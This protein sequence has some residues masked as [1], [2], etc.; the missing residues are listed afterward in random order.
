[1]W[2]ESIEVTGFSASPKDKVEF[3]R[4]AVNLLEEVT[5]Q[6]KLLVPVAVLAA[7][8]GTMANDDEGVD[9]R[10]KVKRFRARDES[11]APFQVVID[12]VIDDRKLRLLR[13][14]LNNEA[15]VYDRTNHTTEVTNEFVRDGL[16][17]GETITG[18][19]RTRFEKACLLLPIQ[20][21]ARRN[22]EHIVLDFM[23]NTAGDGSPLFQE[24]QAV[25]T[26]DE[27]I[28]HFP[29]RT[30]NVKVDF[31]ID[32]LRRQQADI[33]K[34][35]ENYFSRRRA[36][37]PLI[38]RL[39]E[40]EPQ[41]EEEEKRLLADEYFRACLRA[42]ETDGSIMQLRTQRARLQAK[43]RELARL[44]TLQPQTVESQRQVEEL[45]NRRL[46]LL[47]ELNVLTEAVG[48]KI[49]EYDRLEQANQGE[50]ASLQ[51]FTVEHA[52]A[53][54]EIANR[55]A[56]MERELDEFNFQLG[57]RQI[58]LSKQSNVDLKKFEI[59]RK[60]MQALDPQDAN[61]AKSYAALL[62]GFRNQAAEA[63]K[64]KWRA[65]SLINEIEEQRRSKAGVSPLLM[66]FKAN[67]LRQKE[68]EGA[69]ADL[70]RHSAKL[71][72]WKTKIAG[73]EQRL[74]HLAKKA[75][76]EDGELLMKHI[77]EY[78]MA[79]N[80][81]KELDILKQMIE[82]RERN[83]ERLRSE[84][85]P[86]FNKAGRKNEEITSRSAKDLA[87]NILHFRS[88]VV[89]MENDYGPVKEHKEHLQILQA[90][91]NNIDEILA[92]L[93]S[94]AGVE[95]LEDV[96]AG[97]A[98][99][100]S[101]VS[102]FH[103]SRAVEDDIEK[104]LEQAGLHESGED[105][106]AKITRLEQERRT[107]WERIQF[108]VD[109][110]PEIADQIPPTGEQLASKRSPVMNEETLQL[111]GEC[112]QLRAQVRAFFSQSENEYSTLTEKL[113]AI[114]RVLARTES[115]KLALELAKTKLNELLE[116]DFSRLSIES[117]PSL[118]GAFEELPYFIDVSCLG[119]GDI[120][121]CLALKFL[122]VFARKRQIILMC[123][124]HKLNVNRLIQS[125]ALEEEP[126]KFCQRTPTTRDGSLQK[127]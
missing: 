112:D 82:A 61:D 72:E 71:D 14:L 43:R 117:L 63:D 123:N 7:L 93:F 23:I 65:E 3:G 25:H 36:T 110:Y 18:C 92:Q 30:I 88:D 32:E 19:D 69:R 102:A 73:L 97:Y 5:D 42:A 53:L 96:D 105:I 119:H 113:Q 16:S 78:G 2:I 91:L 4:S 67:T 115:N 81:V 12:F 94:E 41:V 75:G 39:R 95:N 84:L 80:K 107:T 48:A 126:I 57:Q 118:K 99:Y 114:E 35:L 90:E 79:S 122:G 83:M 44:D 50:L 74:Q 8:F 45:W 86:Y 40:I 51:G 47:S 101:R 34:K 52:Q 85:E 104:I 127:A 111:M 37:L 55:F 17:L 15:I 64:A 66:V 27:L 58:S 87:E 26:I 59:C 29:Y 13:N 106:N 6:A 77:H 56:T 100:Y 68:L 38:A 120:E 21:G 60:T 76:V 103:H 11:E 124:S 49:S 125:M 10:L 22:G 28:N 9:E 31:L 116:K 20:A 109:N 121:L 24:A 54:Q 1:M 108:L 33:E 62:T 89:S 46:G 70:Q 98:E